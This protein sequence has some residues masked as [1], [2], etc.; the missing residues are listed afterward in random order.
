[1][2]KKSNYLNVK[3]MIL[4]WDTQLR[5]KHTFHFYYHYFIRRNY[6]NTAH[7]RSHIYMIH[8]TCPCRIFVHVNAVSKR[9]YFTFQGNFHRNPTRYIV[10]LTS[11]RHSI[12]VVMLSETAMHQSRR[13]S[14]KSNLYHQLCESSSKT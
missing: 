2:K 6:S 11:H 1:M 5:S 4:P 9:R 8:I 12:L 14:F 10:I 7:A 3:Y 13:Y